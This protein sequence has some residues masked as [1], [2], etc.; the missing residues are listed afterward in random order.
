M[1]LITVTS[2]RKA[3]GR[4]RALDDVSF[5]VRSAAVTGLLGP[6][7]AGKTTTLRILLGLAHADSGTALI[8][9]RP[10]AALEEPLRTVGAVGEDV[11]FHPGRSGRDQ[12]RLVAATVGAP[13]ARADELLALVDLAQE[14]RRAI[15]GYSLGMRQRLALAAALLPD[16]RVLVLDEPMNGLDPHGVRWLRDLLRAEAA[17]GRAVL[18]SSHQLAEMAQ[19]VDDVVVLDRG[20]VVSQGR[21]DDLLRGDVVEAATERASEF[22]IALGEAGLAAVDAGAGVVHVRDTTPEIVGRIAADRGIPLRALGVRS[23]SLEE[24]FVSLT[25]RDD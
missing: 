17:A 23:G 25:R 10:Y 6:N 3:F 20:R 5:V 19:L 14:G 12:L 11:R 22:V 2:L 24:A 1:S 16:P 4:V 8:D 15:G 13:P 21:I 9:G 18:I 7:G